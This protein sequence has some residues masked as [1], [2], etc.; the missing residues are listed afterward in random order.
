MVG[1]V[2]VEPLGEFAYIVRGLAEPWRWTV[3]H[4]AVVEVAPTSECLAVIVTEPFDVKDHL[5]RLDLTLTARTVTV[6]VIYDGADLNELSDR[7]YADVAAIH[8]AGRHVCDFLGFLPGFPYLSGLPEALAGLPRR[9]TPRANVP[10][11]SVAIAGAR[12]GIYPQAS[13]GG[14]WLLGHT[15]IEICDP[16]RDFF[17]IHPGD[18]VIFEAIR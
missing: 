2:T 11:G 14:W 6:P 3:N 5:I 12:C 15:P 18:E 8:Q 16:R 9:A 1:S 4:P 13:P 10:A 17:L 7:L